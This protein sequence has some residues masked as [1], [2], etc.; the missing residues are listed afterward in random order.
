MTGSELIDEQYRDR[1]SRQSP[2]HELN[3]KAALNT[4]L[5]RVKQLLQQYATSIEEDRALL[6]SGTL[7]SSMRNIVLVRMSEKEILQ[8]TIEQIQE[9]KTA[10]WALK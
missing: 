2:I 3:E 8:D 4:L 7:S 6:K 9:I 10:R 1:I 5:T